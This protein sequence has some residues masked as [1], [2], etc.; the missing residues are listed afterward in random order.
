M[1][2]NNELILE[3][4]GLWKNYS[5]YLDRCNILIKA[6]N[7]K[8][9]NEFKKKHPN[10]FTNI[11]LKPYKEKTLIGFLDYLNEKTK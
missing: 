7:T 6:R 2:I 10:S 11:N 5:K 1:K 9:Q 3:A 4:V 8:N